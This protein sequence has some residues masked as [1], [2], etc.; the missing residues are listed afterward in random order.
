MENMNNQGKTDKQYEDSTRAV[1][2]SIIG[3]I[4]LMIFATLSTGCTTTKECCK[5]SDKII[6]HYEKT[7][8]K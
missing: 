2:Y 8:V 4:I 7:S 3:M 1:G 5:N 6:E